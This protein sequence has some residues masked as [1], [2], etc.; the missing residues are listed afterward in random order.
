MILLPVF[1]WTCLDDREEISD[2]TIIHELSAGIEVGRKTGR[3]W[4]E[5]YS[6]D[7]SRSSAVT[8]STK[9]RAK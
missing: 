5:K 6:F 8:T 4:T 2:R 1:V 9:K 3:S 7:R